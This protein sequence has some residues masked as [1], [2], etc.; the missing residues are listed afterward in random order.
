M[1]SHA[2]GFGACLQPWATTRLSAVTT[3][4]KITVI[5]ILMVPFFIVQLM[6][7]AESGNEVN[8]LLAILLFGIEAI[9]DGLDGY[10]A[11]RYN[12]RSDLGAVLDPLA[13]KLLLLSGIVLLSLN[14]G[15]VLPRIPLWLT[16]TILSRDVLLVIG[17]ALLR[18]LNCTVVIRPVF[19]GKVATVL[20]MICVIWG[21]FKWPSEWLLY[22][23][24]A[25][26]VCTGASGII[27]VWLGLRRLSAS[28]TSS[29][30]PSQ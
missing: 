11:R 24:I 3:A 7:Y 9:S 23:S 15:P 1:R 12:Q 28:P 8:W 25:A 14:N 20:Q 5:R 22:W 26:A 16:V 4:N 10:I 19:V 27:Y 21:L 13:D 29:A 17:L 30:S 6:Y 2:T 18:Y